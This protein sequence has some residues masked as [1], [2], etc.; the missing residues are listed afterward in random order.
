[1]L[2]IE[3]L[4]AAQALAFRNIISSD[5]IENI[6]DLYRGDINFLDEDRLLYKDIEK[7]IAFIRNLSID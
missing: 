6:L 5:F 3:L 2:A 4:N 1:M 7:S